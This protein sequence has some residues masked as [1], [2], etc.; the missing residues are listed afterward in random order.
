MFWY[1]FEIQYKPRCENKVVDTLS[2]NPNFERE[3]RALST[4]RIVGLE[5]ID[6]EVT[7]EISLEE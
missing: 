6:Q 3:I 5:E 1:D 7:K 2:H 4:T